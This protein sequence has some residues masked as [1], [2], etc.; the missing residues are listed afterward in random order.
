[1]SV[2][3]V[4]AAAVVAVGVDGAGVTLMV[5]P[6]V[7]DTVHATDRA[8]DELEEWQLTFGQGPCVDAFAAGGPVLV[9]DLGL[10]VARLAEHA[11]YSERM[12]FRLLCLL[13]LGSFVLMVVDGL[14]CG[15]ARFGVLVLIFIGVLGLWSWAC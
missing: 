2:A 10:T 8:A 13:F 12:M 6:T 11:G 9:V 15:G 14:C 1:M 7:R 4:C 5:S 3:H